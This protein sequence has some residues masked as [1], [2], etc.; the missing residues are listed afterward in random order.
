MSKLNIHRSLKDNMC[1]EKY[2]PALYNSKRRAWLA[3]AQI[4]TLPL[5]IELGRFRNIPPI[6][7]KCKHCNEIENEIHFFI[8]CSL[9]EENRNTISSLSDTHPVSGY[10]N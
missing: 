4:G 8:H 6:D 9:F 3:K 1:F 2:I 10:G 5:H 7:R